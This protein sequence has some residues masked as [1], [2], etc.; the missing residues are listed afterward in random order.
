M[1]IDD[2]NK[3]RALINIFVHSVYLYDD[4]FNIILNGSNKQLR[5]EDIPIKSINRALKKNN[6]VEGSTIEES[7]P[8]YK[9]KSLVSGL[10]YYIRYFAHEH[11]VYKDIHT[12][13]KF[14]SFHRLR[15]G[16]QRKNRYNNTGY[17]L[18]KK[19]KRFDEVL[20]AKYY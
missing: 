4:H 9:Q 11:S 6:N 8:P 3:K 5:I 2:L 17:Y 7:V 1:P 19:E 16:N 12:G 18:Y 20:Y 14:F 15:I 13:K 10:F